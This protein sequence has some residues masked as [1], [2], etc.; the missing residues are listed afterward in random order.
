ME[1]MKA[2]EMSIPPALKKAYNEMVTQ[3]MQRPSRYFACPD[4]KI[5]AYGEIKI[6]GTGSVP[7]S[8]MSGYTEL[9]EFGVYVEEIKPGQA[10]IMAYIYPDSIP[11]DTYESRMALV[12]LAEL[13]KAAL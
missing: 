5:P 11:I 9:G 12:T 6:K 13:L 8:E 4:Y 1:I 7:L 10:S 2:T 3:A